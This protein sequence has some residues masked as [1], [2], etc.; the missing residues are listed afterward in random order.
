MQD[1]FPLVAGGTLRIPPNQLSL[2]EEKGGSLGKTEHP[3]DSKGLDQF[4][5]RIG[6]E[7]VGQLLPRHKLLLGFRFIGAHSNNFNASPVEFRNR[8][9]QTASLG[10]ATRGIR[11][12]IEKNQKEAVRTQF[13]QINRLSVLIGNRENRDG[14]AYL[15]GFGRLG[16]K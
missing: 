2:S 14:G 6:Q 3:F 15:D 7:G 9:P 1:D 8:V 16:S 13:R 10:G 11:L 4:A 5:I 12:G